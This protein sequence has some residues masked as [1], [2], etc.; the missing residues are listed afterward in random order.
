LGIHFDTAA[1]AAASGARSLSRFL[2]RCR[3]R[4]F[5]ETNRAGSNTLARSRRTA[6]EHASQMR[7]EKAGVDKIPKHDPADLS[8]ETCLQS[9]V[10]SGEPDIRSQQEQTLNTRERFVET[11]CLEWLLHC[12]APFLATRG[13][14]HD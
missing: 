3:R 12:A 5:Q 9:G 11:L 14:R 1:G 8:V 4:I 10:S 7:L 2:F 13:E 6:D